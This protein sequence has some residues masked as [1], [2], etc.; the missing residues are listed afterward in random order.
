MQDLQTQHVCFSSAFAVS[1]A[2]KNNFE[3]T[4]IEMAKKQGLL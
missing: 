4:D 2:S 1:E 3:N